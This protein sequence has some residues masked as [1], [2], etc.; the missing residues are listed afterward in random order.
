M[1]T[2]GQIFVQ[3]LLVEFRNTLWGLIRNWTC[4]KLASSKAIGWLEILRNVLE[5]DARGRCVDLATTNSNF[6][7]WGTFR[8]PQKHR[9]TPKLSSYSGWSEKYFQNETLCPYRYRRR[10]GMQ[11]IPKKNKIENESSRI[12]NNKKEWISRYKEFRKIDGSKFLKQSNLELLL[13][14][15]FKIKFNIIS[16]TDHYEVFYINTRVENC[17]FRDLISEFL[18]NR[19]IFFS[20]RFKLLFFRTEKNI[21]SD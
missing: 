17:C 15:T 2:R 13:S 8:S 1:I 21:C 10:S 11:I 18:S 9:S 12:K 6:S 5:L 7:A 14:R 3:I 16:K 20:F 4:P 19:S